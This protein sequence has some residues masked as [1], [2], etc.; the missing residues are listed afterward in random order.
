MKKFAVFGGGKMAFEIVIAA[1]D[2]ADVRLSALVS[3]N[4]PDWLQKTEYFSSL[5]QLSA[6][7]D[8][9]IDFTLSGGTC[10]AANWCRARLVPLVSGTT[11]L[12]EKDRSALMEAAELVPVMWAPN[13]SKGLNLLMRSV[14]EVAKAL[15]ADTPVEILDVH[16]AQKID[17][18]SG[19]ALLLARAIASA[20]NQDLEDCLNVVTGEGNRQYK[21]SSINCISRRQGEIIGEHR[22]LFLAG[23]EELEYRHSASD[24]NVYAQ[25]C[26]D[27]ALW[28]V[29]QPAGLYS[30]SDWLSV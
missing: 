2:S 22:V 3:R 13:L 11:A 23:S 18:P 30:S 4:R 17:A 6:L 24:R 14:V 16:H 12:S 7:P 10:D 26:L 28:L 20:R 8:L 1:A 29:R 5:D 27:A 19:T 21:P 9:L 25:G 15:P